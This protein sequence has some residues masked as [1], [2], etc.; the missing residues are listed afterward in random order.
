MTYPE[1]EQYM[2]QRI[3]YATDTSEHARKALDYAR[4]LAKLHQSELVLVHVYEP[5][6]SLLAHPTYDNLLQERISTGHRIMKEVVTALQGDA[7]PVIEELLEGPAARAIVS[8]AN[9]RQCDLIVLGARGLSDLQ[10]LLLGSI[11]HEVIRHAPCPVLV[12]R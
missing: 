11:S 1:K 9:T 8:V 6:S 2:F 5:V 10:S 3:L 7:I 12:V 4:E